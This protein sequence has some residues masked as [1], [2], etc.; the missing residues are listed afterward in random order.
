MGARRSRIGVDWEGVRRGERREK[1]AKVK[2][3]EKK[4]GKERKREKNV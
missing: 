2:K 1:G 3:R 4:R